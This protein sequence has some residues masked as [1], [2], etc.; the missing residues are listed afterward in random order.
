[1]PPRGALPLHYRSSRLEATLRHAVWFDH[2]EVALKGHRGPISSAIWSR[3]DRLVTLAD[4]PVPRL[5]DGKTGKLIAP[6]D[7]AREKVSWSGEVGRLI[8]P[9]DVGGER[10]FWS[11]DGSRLVTCTKGD[12]VARLWDGL[13]GKLIATLEGH[14]NPIEDLSLSEDGSR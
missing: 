8:N 5:W 12:V 2:V 3:E 11:A 4:D 10:V 13:N 6:L 9:F 14:Q 1:L 7:G